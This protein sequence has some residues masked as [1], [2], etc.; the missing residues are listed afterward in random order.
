MNKYYFLLC[1]LPTIEI[2]SKPYVTFVELENY[3]DWNLNEQ[4]KK[5][6][7]KFK[8]YLDFKNLKNFWMNREIDPRGN[9]DDKTIHEVSLREDLLPEYVC[10][11]MKKFQTSEQRINN[12]SIIEIAF[13]RD[14]IE[15]PLSKFLLAYFTL[16]RETKLI[17]T[18]LRAKTLGRDISKELEGEDFD[19]PLI[20]NIISQKDEK[21]YL[22]PQEYEELKD[23]YL[24]NQ[25]DPKALYKAYLE[26]CFNRY[27]EFSE[28]YP[29][30]I[31]QILGYL[32]NLI[33]VEDYNNLDQ[34]RGNLIV[35][36]LL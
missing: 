26:F 5:I 3:L 8:E 25:E 12:F 11:F 1:S 33:L 14:C 9:L 20:Q 4:D 18:A 22:P 2:G 13:I 23:L 10:D 15:H 31:D 7:Y 36:A 6:L 35:Q 27:A 24:K 29:F 28:S 19:D 30:T 34:E 21:A 17:L 16:K 32:A